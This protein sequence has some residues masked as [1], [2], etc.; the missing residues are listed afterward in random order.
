MFVSR[1]CLSL[2]ALFLWVCLLHSIYTKTSVCHNI[3][4]TFCVCVCEDWFVSKRALS[5]Q[6]A[7]FFFPK[8]YTIAATPY[9]GVMEGFISWFPEEKHCKDVS[10]YLHC[11][12]LIKPLE[13]PTHPC[14]FFILCL[15]GGFVL[16]GC[17]HCTFVFSRSSWRSSY[18]EMKGALCLSMFCLCIYVTCTSRHM[19]LYF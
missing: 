16:T 17:Q 6:R 8:L 18:G 14:F 11:S 7:F 3:V 15:F 5:F 4:K 2:S 10:S 12:P 19:Y 13:K 1:I 9:Y